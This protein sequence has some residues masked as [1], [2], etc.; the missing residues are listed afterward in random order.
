MRVVGYFLVD[1]S[2]KGLDEYV[3][4]ESPFVNVLILPFCAIQVFGALIIFP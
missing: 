1:L 4:F 2:T 3:N